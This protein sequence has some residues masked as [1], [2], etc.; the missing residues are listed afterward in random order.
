MK[1]N[2]CLAY[3]FWHWIEADADAGAYEDALK[4]F[5]Q[6]LLANASPGY[7]R[8]AIFRHGPAPWLPA[9]GSY[10]VD[11]YLTDGSAALDPL[12]D[13]AVSVECRAAHDAAAVRAAGGTAGLYAV[14]QGSVRAAEVRWATWFAKPAGVGYEALDVAIAEYT[15]G[16]RSE[17]WSRRMTL[18]PAPE[19]CVLAASAIELPQAYGARSVPME[20]VWPGARSTAVE[21]DLEDVLS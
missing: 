21:G 2:N 7:R 5:Q 9:E 4:S 15:G 8:A 16:I 11:W 20:L 6:A 3:V 12:N 14:R 13:A 17:V 19:M 10:Y 18:G 1:S